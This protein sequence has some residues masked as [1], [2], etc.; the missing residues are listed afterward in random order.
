MKKRFF[1]HTENNATKTL[2]T[3]EK[4]EFKYHN[5]ILLTASFVAAYFILSTDSILQFINQLGYL[6]YPASFFGGLLFTYGITTPIATAFLFNLSKDLNPFY[7]AF[8]G[9]FGAVISDYLIFKFVRSK[10]L[11]EI[12]LLSREIENINSPILS[13]FKPEQRF[14]VNLWRDVSKSKIWH[15]IIPVIAG[16]IIASPLPDEIG[17]ALFGAIKFPT[18]NFL[19]VSYTLNFTGIL[20]IGY[21]VKLFG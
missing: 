12:K 16:F 6:G 7:V 4:F 21:S 13:L 19:F 9:A 10:L 2:K 14:I 18:K 3:I 5:L 15:S 17:I 11:K 20:M 8:I 1:R